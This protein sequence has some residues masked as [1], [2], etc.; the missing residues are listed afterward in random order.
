MD[1][2]IL[3]DYIDACAVIRETEAE[4]RKLEKKRKHVEDKVTGSNPE[5]PYE[6]RSFS[7]RGTV[8]TVA[9]ANRLN[10]EKHILET[11]KKDAEAMKEQVEEWM[12]NIPFRMQRIIRYKYF[13][14]L[15][16]EEVAALM[17]SKQGGEAVRLE[18]YRFMRKK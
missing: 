6:P 7:M 15:S 8:E 4:I 12:K 14:R 18:F 17:K 5:W 3:K 1:K 9:D 10:F 13:H 11:Q 2:R 16:W